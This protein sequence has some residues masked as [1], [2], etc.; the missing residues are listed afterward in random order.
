MQATLIGHHRRPRRS[1]SEVPKS[2]Q[3]TR[4]HDSRRSDLPIAVVTI[5]TFRTYPRPYASVKP[6]SP[7]QDISGA[8]CVMSS[9][10]R[11]CRNEL[12]PSPSIALSCSNTYIEACLDVSTLAQYYRDSARMHIPS[13]YRRA[14]PT[15]GSANAL[16]L[17]KLGRAR[18]DPSRYSVK[19]WARL[20][21]AIILILGLQGTKV[22]TRLRADDCSPQET[23]F[24]RPSA[25]CFGL[26]RSC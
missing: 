25:T 2:L 20:A 24:H 26:R 10:A 16:R 19:C 18:H 11:A 6:I 17:A 14:R 4:T 8:L 3:T 12:F 1:K 22:A 13:I 21:S 23:R 7:L 15:G 5:C 9:P